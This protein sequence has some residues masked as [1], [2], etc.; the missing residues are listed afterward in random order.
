VQEGTAAL[1]AE[2]TKMQI[3]IGE[4]EQ[5]TM[6]KDGLPLFVPFAFV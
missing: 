3:I 6:L 2:K 1:M 4:L 5:Q